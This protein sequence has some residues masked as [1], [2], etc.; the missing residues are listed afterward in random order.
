MN[1]IKVG[2]LASGDLPINYTGN[3]SLNTLL[4]VAFVPLSA[5]KGMKRNVAKMVVNHANMYICIRRCYSRQRVANERGENRINLRSLWN[6][7]LVG[8]NHQSIFCLY[9]GLPVYVYRTFEWSSLLGRQGSKM[10]PKRL[11]IHRI[12]MARRFI[13]YKLT[14]QSGLCFHSVLRVNSLNFSYKWSGNLR[15]IRDL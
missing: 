14:K 8:K 1:I 6:Y 9:I 2:T 15:G 13:F 10:H 7:L 12:V 5:E 4:A 11:Y 3:D